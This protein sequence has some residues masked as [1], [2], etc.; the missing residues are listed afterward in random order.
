MKMANARVALDAAIVISHPE[1]SKHACHVATGGSY[2]REESYIKGKD[3]S[4]SRPC[5]SMENAKCRHSVR[6][7]PSFARAP[8]QLLHGRPS[9]INKR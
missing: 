9:V 1:V 2:K 5:A 4:G 6:R 3:P 7:M 8:C